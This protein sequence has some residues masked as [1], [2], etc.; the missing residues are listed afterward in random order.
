VEAMLRSAG[1]E[2]LEHPEEE[3]YLC[4]HAEGEVRHD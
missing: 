4:R 1:Y 3:V 2:I